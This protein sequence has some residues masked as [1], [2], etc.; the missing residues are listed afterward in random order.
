M[1]NVITACRIICSML[2]LFMPVSSSWFY[3]LY[4]LAGFTDMIDG[5]VARRTHT[6][7]ELGSKLDTIAD[8]VFVFVCLYKFLPVMHITMWMWIW[9]GVIAVIKVTN[10]IC[11]YVYHRRYTAV[12][13]IANKMTGF[14]LFLLPLT[15]QLIE[16]KYSAAIVCAIATFAA[17]Q[18]GHL[19][20]TNKLID[21]E[22]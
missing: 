3:G 12:H 10:I 14:L 1:A 2:L 7:S 5:T 4:L 15:F 19:I 17:V 16:L 13:S 20:R 8:T 22:D 21:E 11:G 6:V 18:E 9:I